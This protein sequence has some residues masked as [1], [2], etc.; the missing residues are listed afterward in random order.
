MTFLFDSNKMKT[1]LL[2]YLISLLCLIISWC[3]INNNSKTNIINQDISI[4]SQ[5]TAADEI[6]ESI[7]WIWYQSHTTTWK[8][9][10]LEWYRDESSDYLWDYVLY[11][12]V[13]GLEMYYINLSWTNNP[14][15]IW[16]IIWWSDTNVDNIYTI[17]KQINLNL[18]KYCELEIS[19]NQDGS[20]SAWIWYNKNTLE[21]LQSLSWDIQNEIIFACNI[22]N[23]YCKNSSKNSECEYRYNLKNGWW[24]SPIV[25]WTLRKLK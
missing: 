18:E 1:K 24:R 5:I 15:H 7:M 4:W 13:D 17:M 16:Q 19:N 21:I 12:E 14:N 23:I 9:T 20:I 6:N 25:I 8:N 2:T 10:I 11:K 3:S 22:G